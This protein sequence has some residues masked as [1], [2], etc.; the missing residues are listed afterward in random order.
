[1]ATN[2]RLDP[3]SWSTTLDSTWAIR[4]SHLICQ[5]VTGA[6]GALG[7]DSDWVRHSSRMARLMYIRR[8]GG[9]S[10]CPAC[11]SRGGKAK[12][13]Q[14]LSQ[15]SFFLTVMF[16]GAG[17][18]DGWSCAGDRPVPVGTS[19]LLA[20][21]CCSSWTLGIPSLQSHGLN[22]TQDLVISILQILPDPRRISNK[23][24]GSI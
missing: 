24:C 10:P 19:E 21:L 8:M 9:F 14:Q 23:L 17:K 4:E 1:M 3:A 12:L 18:V 22:Q 7:T 2:T 13:V 20:D 15:S 16:L 5:S 6:L 11:V